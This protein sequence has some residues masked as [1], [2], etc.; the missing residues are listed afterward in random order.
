VEAARE[1][2]DRYGLTVE[3]LKQKMV[4]FGSKQEPT[5]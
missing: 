2:M 5:L 3:D 4:L 1:V